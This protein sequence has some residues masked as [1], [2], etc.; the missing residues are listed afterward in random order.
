MFTLKI[1]HALIDPIFIGGDR[2]LDTSQ[3][4]IEMKNETG[5]EDITGVE[6]YCEISLGSNLKS[7][8]VN[9]SNLGSQATESQSSA[10][11]GRF[12]NKEPCQ[13]RF[14]QSAEYSETDPV[15]ELEDMPGLEDVPGLE[16]ILYTSTNS[17]KSSSMNSDRESFGLMAAEVNKSGDINHKLTNKEAFHTLEQNA[18]RQFISSLDNRSLTWPVEETFPRMSP[19]HEVYQTAIQKVRELYKTWKSRS[20][21]LAEMHFMNWLQFKPDGEQWQKCTD[22]QELSK[23]LSDDFEPAWVPR[24]FLWASPAVS[25]DD[26][27]KLGKFFPEY[28][29]IQLMVRTRLTALHN[30]WPT[31]LPNLAKY[32]RPWLLM[33]FDAL[34]TQST[35]KER[36][37]VMDFPL[38]EVPLSRTR[39]STRD[40]DIDADGT[41][42]PVRPFNKHSED[43]HSESKGSLDRAG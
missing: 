40:I 14:Y 18:R 43:E 16:Y 2:F 31:D 15:P 23:G 34:H 11:S 7:S 38:Q 12:T 39:I 21:H 28:S 5:T 4:Q 6:Q 9:K 22:F 19:S 30:A 25:Y 27:S 3:S 8:S 24:V 36:L 41:G 10:G 1:K 13:P 42:R 32:D 35:F 37:S 33:C 29:T 20:L 17:S 26:C